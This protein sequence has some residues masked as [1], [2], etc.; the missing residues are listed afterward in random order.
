MVREPADIFYPFSQGAEGWSGTLTRKLRTFARNTPTKRK[1]F[2]RR[3]AV[4]WV[5]YLVYESSS[6]V[7]ALCFLLPVW[8]VQKNKN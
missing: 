2:P 5:R 4:T 6:M 3:V 7:M 8:V 1:S